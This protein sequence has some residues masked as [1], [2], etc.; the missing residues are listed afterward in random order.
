MADKFLIRC[1]YCSK[2]II[3]DGT[4]IKLREI[5]LAKIPGKIPYLENGKMISPASIERPKMYRC[6]TCGR[7]MSVRKSYIP[8][9][10]HEAEIDDPTNNSDGRETGFNGSKIQD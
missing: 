5:P 4:D 1:D 7:G 8:A 6:P 3:T 9:S 10:K 2:T